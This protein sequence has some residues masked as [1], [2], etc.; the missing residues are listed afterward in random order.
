MLALSISST[1]VHKN[2]F[3]L[4]S[5]TDLQSKLE[6]RFFA[7]PTFFW[8]SVRL[9]MTDLIVPDSLSQP[10]PFSYIAYL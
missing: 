6:A 2:Q 5:R 1:S 8:V 4:C 3:S 10:V 7:G 9:V